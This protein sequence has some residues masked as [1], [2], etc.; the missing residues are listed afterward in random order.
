MGVQHWLGNIPFDAEVRWVAPVAEHFLYSTLCRAIAGLSYGRFTAIRHKFHCRLPSQEPWRV[1]RDG[2]RDL[3]VGNPVSSIQR[4]TQGNLPPKTK[5]NFPPPTPQWRHM[6][7]VDFVVHP[8]G[9][10]RSVTDL[11]LGRPWR[12]VT[13][14]R[15]CVSGDRGGCSVIYPDHGHRGNLPLQG[16]FPR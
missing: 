6:S 12:A 2:Y 5:I 7:F 15:W 11:R 16:K 14:S 13:L 4:T 3:W 9:H 10:G 8:P 1:W